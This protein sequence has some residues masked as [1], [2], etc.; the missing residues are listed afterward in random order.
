MREDRTLLDFACGIAVLYHTGA[1]G[2]AIRN[3]AKRVRDR[4]EPQWRPFVDLCIES[5][6]KRAFVKQ[7]LIH[8]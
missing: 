6:D 3:F 5:R 4:I 8:Y 2:N 1:D 7:F